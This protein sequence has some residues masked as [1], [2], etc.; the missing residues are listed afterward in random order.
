[1][2]KISY[3]F[4]FLAILMAFPLFTAASG[5]S[6]SIFPETVEQG[7]PLMIQL[8]GATLDET[9]RIL[10]NNKSLWFFNYNGRP[11]AFY[12][13][14]LSAKLGENKIT[15][16]MENGS[17][18][19]KTVYIK[20]RAKVEAP[21]GIPEKLGGDTPQA[22]TNLVNN[23]IKE[24]TVI[25]NVLSANRKY[26]RE[27]FR[28]PLKYPIVTD[29]YGYLRKTGYYSIPH[30][31]TDFRAEEGY[32]VYSINRGVVRLARSFTIYGKTV[33]VD[34]GLGVVSYYMHLSRI[35][36]KEGQVVDKGQVIGLSGSTGYSEGPHLHLSIKIN[37]IS[38]DPDK[39]LRM[40]R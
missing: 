19:Q 30:K 15:V 1:M 32:R 31:G 18:I 8:E 5:P 26:W 35:D 37:G 23:L 27:S 28:Y 36:V 24:N 14:D 6:I 2:N 7:E 33:A 16:K 10:W 25:N 13:I 22:A 17:S 38:I 12:G 3:I 4:F 20:E 11:T 40:F 39:F 34:H 29:S 9:Q 21:L